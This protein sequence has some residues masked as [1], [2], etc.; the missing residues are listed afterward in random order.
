MRKNLVRR[1]TEANLNLQILSHDAALLIGNTWVRVDDW[2]TLPSLGQLRLLPSKP[3]HLFRQLPAM[4]PT[5][6]WSGISHARLCPLAPFQRLHFLGVGTHLSFFR[7]LAIPSRCHIAKITRAVTTTR[8]TA[9]MAITPVWRTERIGFDFKQE[10]QEAAA[11]RT[12]R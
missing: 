5:F 3:L 7:R 9:I 1:T 2:N 6:R 11:A 10:E 8:A 12:K 4:F